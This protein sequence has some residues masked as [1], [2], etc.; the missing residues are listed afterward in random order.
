MNLP[1]FLNQVDGLISSSDYSKL[2]SFVHDYARTLPENQRDTFL[3]RLQSF[4]TGKQVPETGIISVKDDVQ[5]CMKRLKDIRKDDHLC[6]DSEYNEDYDDWYDSTDDEIFFEDPHHILHTID[7]AF[8]L[9]HTCLD[10]AEYQNGYALSLI[11]SKVS[12]N[13]TGDYH[14]GPMDLTDLNI[15]HLI[16]NNRYDR[17]PAEAAYLAYMSSVPSERAENICHLL[18]NLHWYHFSLENMMQTGDHDLPDFDNFLLSWIEILSSYDNQFAERLLREAVS[19]ATLDQQLYYAEKFSGSHPELYLNILETH[20]ADKSSTETMMNAGIKALDHIPVKY[21]IRSNI[22]LLTAEFAVLQGN[23]KVREKACLEAFRSRCSLENYLRIR[24]ECNEN[25][26]YREECR[27][28]YE[29]EHQTENRKYYSSVL[30][31]TMDPLTE[32]SLGDK[33]YDALLFFDERFSKLLDLTQSKHSEVRSQSF[34]RQGI[35]LF[36]LLVQDYETLPK[37]MRSMLEIARSES[38]IHEET[39]FQGVAGKPAITNDQLFES[40]FFRWKNEVHLSNEIR[41]EIMQRTSQLIKY[42]A[43]GIMLSKRRDD[44]EECAAFLA[45]CGEAEEFL[46]KENAKRDL[47]ESWRSAYP[48]RSSFTGPLKNYL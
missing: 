35:A 40:L 31:G 9:V 3:S 26:H 45:A 41:N 28:I 29:A 25:D 23:E 47:L 48:R 6:L 44:Y 8:D 20:L 14:N 5:Q 4:A 38:G 36:L 13:V 42:Y 34:T 2:S 24:L 15:Y 18:D 30:G 7:Q 43:D 1:V 39:Y 11:L 17:L 21:A 19:M 22:A 37:G 32:N 10:L 16:D 33:E 46:G 27:S 12:V